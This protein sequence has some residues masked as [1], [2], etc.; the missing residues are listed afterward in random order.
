MKNTLKYIAL[1]LLAGG[2]FAC[3]KQEI[4]DPAKRPVT[5]IEMSFCRDGKA[6]DT[7]KVSPMAQKA[8]VDIVINNENLNWTVTS[9]KGWCRI[10]EGRGKGSQTIILDIDVNES[11][12]FAPR[13]TAT[14]VFQAGDYIAPAKLKVCQGSTTFIISQP[15]FVSSKA[16]QSWTSITV[17]S[18]EGVG[19]TTKGP[20]WITYSITRTAESKGVRTTTLKLTS[21]SNEG[22]SRYDVLEFFRDDQSG[23]AAARMYFHQFGSELNYDASGNILM[24][25]TVDSSIVFRAPADMVNLQKGIT[26]SSALSDAITMTSKA[27]PDGD[28]DISINFKNNLNDCMEVRNVKNSYLTLYNNSRCILPAIIQPYASSHGISTGKGF[29]SFAKAVNE[30]R[31]IADWETDGKVRI[32]NNI[33][34]SSVSKNWESIGTEENPFKGQFDGTYH[35][36]SGLSTSNPLFGVCKDATIT[37]V[38]IDDTNVFKFTE[39]P[40][41]ESGIIMAAVAADIRSTTMTDCASSA[42][43]SL[44]KAVLGDDIE[45]LIGAIAAKADNASK[46]S[47][48]ENSGDIA[49]TSGVTTTNTGNKLYIGGIMAKGGAAIDNCVNKGSFTDA[50]YVH[51]HYEGGIAGYTS[52]DVKNC[53]NAGNFSISAVRD[54]SKAGVS[55]AS[56]NIYVGGISGYNLAHVT[57]NVNSGNFVITSNVKSFYVGGISGYINAENA[58]LSGNFSSGNFDST[59]LLRYL[60]YGGLYGCLNKPQSIDYNGVGEVVKGDFSL[61]GVE[62]SGSSQ[63][64]VGGIIGRVNADLSLS[65]PYWN[66]SI[67]IDFAK[68]SHKLGYL[69]VGGIVGGAYAPYAAEAVK[70]NITIKSAQNDKGSIVMNNA[71]ANA[72]GARWGSLA[73]IIGTINGNADIEDCL[74]TGDVLMA[75]AGGQ[76]NTYSSYV[77]GIV[78]RIVGGNAVIANCTNNGGLRNWQYNN[79]SYETTWSSE[80]TGMASYTCNQTAGILGGFIFAPTNAAHFSLEISGCSNTGYVYSYRGCAAGIVGHAM[81]A[82]ITNCTNTGSL[83][84]GNRFYIGGVAGIVR[85]STISNCSATCLVFG[86]NAGSG[87]FAGGGIAS[88]ATENTAITDCSYFGDIT[89]NYKSSGTAIGKGECYGG[90]AGNTDKTTNI[91]RCKFGGSLSGVGGE[92]V[93]VELNEENFAEHISGD[94]NAV[95]SECSY[96]NGK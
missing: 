40:Q 4:D 79:N 3:Q 35:A 63:V 11:A 37:A 43:I 51:D 38:L 22:Q 46:I 77:C 29:L 6:I 20:E 84:S 54:N 82:K 89:F 2:L 85:N 58:G 45:I 74:N 42:K 52:A 80:D 32:L 7:L 44:D 28:V 18:P 17:K 15:Y 10:E 96:W 25:A 30:G 16:G 26:V 55:D 81:D 34:M 27:R 76:A 75:S 14:L 56:K 19:F 41:S 23:D 24:P 61:T 67:S 62:D 60:Y 12:T 90:I 33:D 31:S 83:G 65:H 72:Y 47:K 68:S 94:G 9:D 8:P 87:V 70:A 21:A 39:D 71:S 73:G 69:S 49:V 88:R 78:G 92:S 64:V 13:D 59:G 57:D 91:T 93:K 86:Q 36:I 53:S 48:C 1:A 66:R 50:G 95:T 5:Q